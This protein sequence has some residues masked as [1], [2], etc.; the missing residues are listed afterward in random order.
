[1]AFKPPRD[2]LTQRPK[3]AFLQ[4]FERMLAARPQTARMSREP[5]VN[6]ATMERYIE[7]MRVRRREKSVQ[8]VNE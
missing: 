5:L 7:R 1:M 8:P 4:R 3:P 2:L 6:E